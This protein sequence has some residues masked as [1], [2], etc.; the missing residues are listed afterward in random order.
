MCLRCTKASRVS[1]M[2]ER[3][4]V[5]D[6]CDVDMAL[7]NVVISHSL[8]QSHG[9]ESVSL[10][11]SE[12]SINNRTH[13]SNFDATSGTNTTTASAVAVLRCV[14]CT[15]EQSDPRDAYTKLDAQCHNNNNI[16]VA[17]IILYV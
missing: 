8:T 10:W 4:V 11:T 12:P 17:T 15:T 9:F 6:I 1:R 13:T 14:Q 16:A 5:V 2:S 7:E 3:A